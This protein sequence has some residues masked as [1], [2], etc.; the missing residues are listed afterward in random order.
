VAK[1]VRERIL[2]TVDD[3]AGRFLYYDRKEDGDL[4]EDAIETAI[5]AGEITV[6]EIV[7]KFRSGLE[8]AME[9]E[10]SR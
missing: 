2:D 5:A 8:S 3:L 10:P 9:P 1:T 6:D 4:P 7:G